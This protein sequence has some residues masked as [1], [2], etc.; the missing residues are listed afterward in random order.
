MALIVV[1]N[2]L[3][4]IQKTNDARRKSDLSQIQKAVETYYNDFGYYPVADTSTSN[5]RIK[6]D[7]TTTLE[8]GSTGWQYI[9][10]LPKDP[11]S[12]RNYVYCSPS[13]SNGQSYYLYTSLE[14][15]GNQSL[16]TGCSG[17]SCGASATC[18]YGVSSPNV[19][20]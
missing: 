7:A 4:Q 19:S 2:P 3:A 11:S 5:Y 18:N 20:P 12:T 17:A 1:L 16:P 6:A 15:G 10:A 14:R 8:W 9:N 13:S